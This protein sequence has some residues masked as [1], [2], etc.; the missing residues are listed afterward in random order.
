MNAWQTLALVAT[1]WNLAALWAPPVAAQDGVARLLRIEGEILITRSNGS[2][3]GTEGSTLRPGDRLI[4]LEGGRGSIR[5]ADG[6]TY[7]LSDHAIFTVPATSPCATGW[8]PAVASQGLTG[9]AAAAG[10]APFGL[11]TVPV[12]ILPEIL[13]AA[14][15][16]GAIFNTSNDSGGDRPAISP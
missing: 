3:S 7:P 11:G 13:G 8:T 2:V 9:G 14:A 6:C 15:A 5:F 1:V 12:G 16:V 10:A 4:V